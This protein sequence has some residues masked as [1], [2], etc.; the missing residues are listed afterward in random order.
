[1]VKE[2]DEEWEAR[3]AAKAEAKA[4][5][6][7]LNESASQSSSSS[8]PVNPIS[9]EA[10]EQEV[11]TAD[12]DF[13]RRVHYIQ[14]LKAQGQKPHGQSNLNVIHRPTTPQSNTGSTTPRPNTGSTTPRPNTGSTTPRPTT[15]S[16][17]PRPVNG[18]TTPR[19]A[20]GS[21]A[22]RTPTTASLSRGFT[23][24]PV[25]YPFLHGFSPQV[26][27]ILNQF[28][29]RLIQTGGSDSQERVLE[30]ETSTQGKDSEDTVL[31]TQLETA[32]DSQKRVQ[33]TQLSVAPSTESQ[34]YIPETQIPV[35]NPPSQGRKHGLASPTTT[36]R[37]SRAAKRRMP[38]RDKDINTAPPA[39]AKPTSNTPNIR[40]SSR[41]RKENLHK[42]R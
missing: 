34:E 10:Y 19:P 38:L 30:T 1:M 17:T 31:E 32:L 40:R 9:P 37:G 29:E 33:E 3:R 12:N 42:T 15:G 27:S 13:V 41:T 24:D 23:A 25:A 22:P 36:P 28:R 14:K 26:R 21:K 11:R 6:Q 8:A 18:S 20:T 7:A 4:R 5:E 16:T 39:M 2:V 35:I